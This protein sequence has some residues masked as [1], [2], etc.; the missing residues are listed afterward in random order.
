MPIAA[1]LLPPL[2]CNWQAAGVSWGQN[3]SVEQL[4]L[5]LAA[6]ETIA[7]TMALLAAY[8]FTLLESWS[9]LLQEP[10]R[11]VNPERLQSGTDEQSGFCVL[12]ASRQG[13]LN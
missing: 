7:E 2:P 1:L 9:I 10:E 13:D 6:V 12:V 11:L 5:R 4:P 8:G 3:Q